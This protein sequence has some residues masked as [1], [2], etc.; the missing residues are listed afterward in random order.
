MNHPAK[1]TCI[2]LSLP[3]WL[4][5]SLVFIFC[6]LVKKNTSEFFFW[7]GKL[8]EV[9]PVQSAAKVKKP[10][11]RGSI[12]VQ[13]SR[14]CLEFGKISKGI[15]MCCAS[16]CQ[17]TWSRMIKSP[18]GKAAPAPEQ[19]ISWASPEHPKGNTGGA[20]A[21]GWAQHKV[22]RKMG[23]RTTRG[24]CRSAPGRQSLG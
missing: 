1:K 12:S 15:K 13:P 17:R 9:F 4:C 24:K 18:A 14:P 3:A 19:K 22:K 5:C 20:L 11:A 2:N 7:M 21:F 23:F 6:F 16:N 8:L 10:N